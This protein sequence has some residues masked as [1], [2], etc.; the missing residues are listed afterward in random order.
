MS[1]D[2]QLGRSVLL[3]ATDDE[4]VNDSDD[5]VLLAEGARAGILEEAAGRIILAHVDEHGVLEVQINMIYAN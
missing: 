4:E 1:D 2:D 3:S 5:G